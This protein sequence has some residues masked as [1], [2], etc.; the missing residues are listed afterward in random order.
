ML[1]KIIG[2]AVPFVLI[3][4]FWLWLKHRDPDRA[5]DR[6]RVRFYRGLL[7]GVTFMEYARTWHSEIGT[8]W[9]NHPDLTVFATLIVFGLLF[10]LI[11]EVDIANLS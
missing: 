8:A 11:R 5:L 3:A 1:Q 7:I 2:P 6:K 10:T 9:Q 4:L